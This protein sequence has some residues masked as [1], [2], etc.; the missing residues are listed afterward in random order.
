MTAGTV[1]HPKLEWRTVTSYVLWGTPYEL[2]PEKGT[3]RW[4]VVHSRDRLVALSEALSLGQAK[5]L[6]EELAREVRS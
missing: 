6:A 5:Q 3:R 1:K 4:F 2:V